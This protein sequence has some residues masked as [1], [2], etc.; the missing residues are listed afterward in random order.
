MKKALRGRADTRLV[1]RRPHRF[2]TLP[3]G[4]VGVGVSPSLDDVTMLPTPH[5]AVNDQGVIMET[6]YG[7]RVGLWEGMGFRFRTFKDVDGNDCK[8]GWAEFGHLRLNLRIN[9]NFSIASVDNIETNDTERH[10]VF[11]EDALEW[12]SRVS[13]EFVIAS[14]GALQVN[15]TK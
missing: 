6:L 3:E 5:W 11:E 4:Q 9:P 14:N 7:F 2:T 10:A 8:E 1:V 12:F 15:K 13:E